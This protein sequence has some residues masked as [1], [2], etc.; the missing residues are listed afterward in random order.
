MVGK[1][2]NVIHIHV[3]SLKYNRDL[4]LAY[5][6]RFKLGTLTFKFELARPLAANAELIL[7]S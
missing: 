2:D 1:L 6:Y 5:S 7:I 4:I 3:D